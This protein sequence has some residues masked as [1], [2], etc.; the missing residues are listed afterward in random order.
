TDGRHP[1]LAPPEEGNRPQLPSLE[2][3]G[4]GAV[5]F[6]FPAAVE[7]ARLLLREYGITIT[8]KEALVIGRGRM[9]AEPFL[10]M[11]LAEGARG[12]R[13]E[14][15]V[16]DL[17]ARVARADIVVAAVGRAGFVR[18]NWLK[19]GAAV[20]DA[21]LNAGPAGPVGDVDAETVRERAGHLT[22]VP[23]GIGTITLAVLIE[24][25]LAAAQRQLGG[26]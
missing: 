24:R 22:P 12:G 4:E 25:T 3:P 6:G 1:P 20:I 14:P 15:D 19:P 10:A 7:G 18:G 23:G 2:G 9:L 11:L 5:S 21:G 26:G 13:V 8:G 16:P 17:P